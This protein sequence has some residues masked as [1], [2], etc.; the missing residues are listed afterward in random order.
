[1]SA[2]VVRSTADPTK[3]VLTIE[4]LSIPGQ[5]QTL[6]KTAP[7]ARSESAEVIV[8]RPHV[9]TLGSTWLGSTWPT[10]VNFPFSY[11]TVDGAPLSAYDTLSIQGRQADTGTV[12]SPSPATTDSGGYSHFTVSSHQG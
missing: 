11:V 8:E 2:S 12:Y 5:R 1:M 9:F 3:Y 7:A 6:T 10:A 4:N